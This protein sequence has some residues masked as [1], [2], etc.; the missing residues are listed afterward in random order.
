VAYVDPFRQADAP[1][2]ELAMRR[3]KKPPRRSSGPQREDER[4]WQ[5]SRVVSQHVLDRGAGVAMASALALGRRGCVAKLAKCDAHPPFL[6]RSCVTQRAFTT[7]GEHQPTKLSRPTRKAANRAAS[8]GRN[9]SADSR[10]HCRSLP[11]CPPAWPPSC[12]A[13]AATHVGRLL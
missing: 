9:M 13:L 7:D 12:A 10:S 3:E 4:V 6:P 11:D 2:H 5:E 1:G 8:V